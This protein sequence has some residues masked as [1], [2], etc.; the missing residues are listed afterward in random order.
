MRI[1]LWETVLFLLS[2]TKVNKCFFVY[3]GLS[4]NTTDYRFQLKTNISN[5]LIW[6]ESKGNAL[7]SNYLA[8][9]LFKRTIAFSINLGGE[10]AKVIR[11]NTIINDNQWHSVTFTRYVSFC[12][13]FCFFYVYLSDGILCTL[14]Q[15]HSN[16]RKSELVV[17]GERVYHISPVG[18]IELNT[19]RVIWIGKLHNS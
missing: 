15:L 2:Y 14:Y 8:I 10:R 4:K 16:R 1:S 18:S 13:N 3:S 19:D 12:Y 11:S 9:F 6:W 5:G 17:D 7:R